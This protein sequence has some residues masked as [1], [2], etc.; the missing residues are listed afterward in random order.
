MG[1]E[2][3]PELAALLEFMPPFTIEDVPA[4]REAFSAVMAGI[5]AMMWN[6]WAM[7]MEISVLIALIGSVISF[8]IRRL[9]LTKNGLSVAKR[10]V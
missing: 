4:A 7:M 10:G 6:T 2:F 5:T 8:I 3:D 1:Y 9:W